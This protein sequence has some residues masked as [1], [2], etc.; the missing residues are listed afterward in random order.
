MRKIVF[1]VIAALAAG[2]F[3]FAGTMYASAQLTRARTTAPAPLADV[4]PRPS[5]E[6]T[7]LSGWEC[8]QQVAEVAWLMTK[9][10]VTTSE[11]RSAV[12]NLDIETDGGQKQ[13][14]IAAIDAGDWDALGTALDRMSRLC[15]E[16]LDY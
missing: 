15:Y 14:A 1:S 10:G 4:W 7:A 6:G 11:L 13:V 16:P 2:A 3:L 9:P 12:G 5:S 8:E